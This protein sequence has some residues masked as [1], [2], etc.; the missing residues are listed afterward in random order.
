MRFTQPLAL[1]AKVGGWPRLAGGHVGMCRT[2]MESTAVVAVWGHD[3]VV[4]TSPAC[5]ADLP[6]YRS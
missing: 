1:A 6:H 4:P 2:V 5:H 3:E